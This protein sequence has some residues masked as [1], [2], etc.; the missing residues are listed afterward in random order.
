MPMYAQ[1]VV[2]ITQEAA[3]PSRDHQARDNHGPGRQLDAT[4]ST[5]T[6]GDRVCTF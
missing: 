2:E 5:Q 4:T 1:T 3:A 6:T